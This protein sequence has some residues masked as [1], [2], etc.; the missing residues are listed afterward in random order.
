MGENGASSALGDGSLDDALK[1]FEKKFK[2][3]TGNMWENRDAPSK[4]KKVRTSKGCAEWLPS[5]LTRPLDLCT[6]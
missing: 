6:H 4:A 2:D 3:K 5:L 1:Q